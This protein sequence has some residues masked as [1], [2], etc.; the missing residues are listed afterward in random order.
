M[1]KL[2]FDLNNNEVWL[3]S[4][5]TN[6]HLNIL[7]T[8]FLTPL[9]ISTV[10]KQPVH[11]YLSH[12][13]TL[14]YTTQT[15][16]MDIRE[17]ITLGQTAVQSPLAPAE[18]CS[19]PHPTV[20]PNISNRHRPAAP[21]PHHQ[22]VPAAAPLINDDLCRR[23]R[24]LRDRGY[25]AGKGDRCWYFDHPCGATMPQCHTM[26]GR[27]SSSKGGGEGRGCAAGGGGGG[28][29]ERQWPSSS[30]AVAQ[31]R[32]R[33]QLE[34]SHRQMSAGRL[35]ITWSAPGRTSSN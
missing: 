26:A 11:Y 33:H 3:R 21:C 15:Q 16:G 28:G 13:R 31:G 32:T 7:S 6:K 17:A 27:G 35:S 34:M 10:F 25:R 5:D 12:T 9:D 4:S 14:M 20:S 23:D 8:P 19:A 22:S 29:G 30:G 24:G 2:K 18:I 1:F